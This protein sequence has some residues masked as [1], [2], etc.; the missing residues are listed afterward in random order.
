[1]T[2]ARRAALALATAAFL[3]RLGAI[4]VFGF[5]RLEF[6]DARDY[7]A[8]A[9]SLCEAGVY[10][11]QGNLPFFRAPGLPFFIVLATACEPQHV[12]AVKIALALI[13]SLTV[14]LIV[15]LSFAV[16]S[17]LQGAILAGLAAA[18]DPLFIA[19][20]TDIRSEP[21]FMFFLVASLFALRKRA[22]GWSGA[23]LALAAL[24]RPIALIFAPLFLLAFGRRRNGLAFIAAFA[25]TL[26]PWVIRNDARYGEL[27][28][29]N[30]AAGYNL[31]RGTHPEMARLYAIRDHD[32][33]RRASVNFEQHDTLPT[34]QQIN[35]IAKTP[36]ARSAAWRRAAFANINMNP[37]LEA[38]FA[39]KKAW[40]YW[41]PWLNPQEFNTRVV[42]L[43]GIFTA[44]LY[45][46]A[47]C[48]LARTERP[49][50]LWIIAFF[51][52]GWIVH[53]PN[54]VVTR[55]R[56]PL[57]DPLLLI[58]AA[59]CVASSAIRRVGLSSASRERARRWTARA[60]RF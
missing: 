54:Q 56:Y 4:G 36:R 49:V 33:F 28:V 7:L 40:L 2:P 17:S 19:C 3:I 45:A 12:A 58:A 37:R 53:I 24:T 11:A 39:L 34:M 22:G 32:E 52:I 30:D 6:G 41:R 51:V 13:D 8:T 60:L 57:T 16:Y 38:A 9:S 46:L 25:L 48:G 21:L 50:V 59:H 43:S 18:C 44:A 55:F 23:T 42:I 14:A 5:D 29:V 27:I 10:P 15:L 35:A 1:M 20:V 47:L 26:A 31:W